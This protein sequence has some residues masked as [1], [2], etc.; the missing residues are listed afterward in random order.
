MDCPVELVWPFGVLADGQRLG[1]CVS[2]LSGTTA[3]RRV[4][5]ALIA[6]L[7]SAQCRVRRKSTSPRSALMA[8]R[9]PMCIQILGCAHGANAVS[10]AA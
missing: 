7:W 9:V 1:R 2:V 4:H 6:P 8:R 10:T 3:L 5:K